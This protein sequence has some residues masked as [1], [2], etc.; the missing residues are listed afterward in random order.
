MTIIEKKVVYSKWEQVAIDIAQEGF[1]LLE[2]KYRNIEFFPIKRDEC[3]DRLRNQFGQFLEGYYVAPG[4]REARCDLKKVHLYYVSLD[5]V[6]RREEE[7][8]RS[9]EDEEQCWLVPNQ[10]DY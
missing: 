2:R 6:W 1:A 10:M 3:G 4:N 8:R 9:R 5:V 7:S